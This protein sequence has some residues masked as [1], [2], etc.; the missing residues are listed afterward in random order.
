MMFSR[1]VMLSM[2]SMAI[3]SCTAS[4]VATAPAPIG[5]KEA[6]LLDKELKGKVAGQ[7][8]N[9]ISSTGNVAAIRISD[10]MLLYRTSGRVVYQNRLRFACR[11]LAR[12]H[13][14]MVNRTFGSQY[15]RG[16]IFHLVDPTSGIAGPSCILGEFIP[17][18]KNSSVAAQ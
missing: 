1:L 8:V 11:G 3:G 17:Y 6:R 9:C 12:D 13:D 14:I 18:R 7:P 15:C 2:L 4:D 16:D 5:E 10:D